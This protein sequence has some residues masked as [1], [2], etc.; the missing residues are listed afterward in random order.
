MIETIFSS[1]DALVWP[2]GLTQL[3]AR[4]PRPPF[5]PVAVEFVATLSSR[6]LRSP[7]VRQH[8]ELAAMAHWFRRAN[9]K[10]MDNRIRMA[11]RAH[12]VC[13]RGVVFVLAPSNVE[14]LFIYVWLLSLLAGN[15][16]I[17]RVSQKPST[18]RDV[19]L[20]M[21]REVAASGPLAR[22]LNDSWLITYGHEVTIT[23]QISAV[24]H[25]RLVWGGDATVAQIRSIPLNPLAVDVGFADRFSFAAFAADRVC[26]DDDA[27]LR[28]VARRF[29]NDTLWSAQQACSS[30]RAVVWVGERAQAETARRRFWPLYQSAAG[31]FENEPSAVMTRVADL[32]M[33]AGA[34]AIDRLGD[35]LSAFPGRAVGSSTFAKVRAFH[36]GC[37]MFVEY[38]VGSA[39][40][41]SPLMASKDQTLVTYGLGAEAIEGLVALLPNRA[42]DRIVLPGEANDFSTVWD[43]SDLFEL[44][45]RKVSV[46]GADRAIGGN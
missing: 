5:E 43:G 3:T 12:R 32:F 11:E 38:F 15:V 20:S 13:A 25:A 17:V 39:A 46:P 31:A 26:A 21:V 27:T 36:S 6:I 16:S 22:A 30:P 10:S 19:V 23:A 37:G 42:L 7:L 33:L 1:G 45:T 14:V 40:E 9:L 4:R 34:G 29:V 24:C 41:I 18:L 35:T 2:A 28:E 8:P 44:L